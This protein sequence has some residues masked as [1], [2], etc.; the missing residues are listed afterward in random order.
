MRRAV[1][2]VLRAA[3]AR[4]VQ[5]RASDLP[6]VK[7]VQPLHTHTHTHTV[8]RQATSNSFFPNWTGAAAPPSEWQRAPPVEWRNEPPLHTADTDR[9]LYWRQAPVGCQQS[10]LEQ[11]GFAGI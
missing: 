1:E 5:T 10:R 8:R 4:P 2:V 6:A 9:R 11:V 3:R 7:P